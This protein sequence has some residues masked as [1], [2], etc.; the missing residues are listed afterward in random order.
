LQQ[1]QQFQESQQS[2]K[3]L[4]AFK[5]QEHL[6]KRNKDIFKKLTE[7]YAVSD[8]S[9]KQKVSSIDNNSSILFKSARQVGS[10][11]TGDVSTTI[12][13]LTARYTSMMDNSNFL[14]VYTATKGGDD[15]SRT[16]RVDAKKDNYNNVSQNRFNGA[17]PAITERP[18][19]LI[20]APKSPTSTLYS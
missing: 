1:V 7:E 18:N 4:E 19:A 5:T 6:S 11:L 20:E 9:L 16:L 14:S 10:R 2:N 13:D 3:I 12:N 8:V 15:K 17:G